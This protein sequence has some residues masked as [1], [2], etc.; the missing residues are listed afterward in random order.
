MAIGMSSRDQERVR[1]EGV[2]DGGEF[3]DGT[4]AEYDAPGRRELEGHYQPSSPG[5]M[6]KYFTAVRGSAIISGTASRHLA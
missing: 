2:N 3:R 5:L 6:F 4:G 1:A